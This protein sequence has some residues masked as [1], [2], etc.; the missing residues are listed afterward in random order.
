MG[1]NAVIGGS[2]IDE[3]VYT[4]PR[5]F[6]ALT[7]MTKN[8][9]GIVSHVLLRVWRGEGSPLLVLDTTFGGG[10]THTLVALYHLFKHPSIAEQDLEIRKILAEKDLRSVPNVAL[11]AID[12]HS[13]SSVQREG[14]VRTIWGEMA[15]QLGKYEMMEVYDQSLRRPDYKALQQLF[16]SVGNQSLFSLMN[17][18]IT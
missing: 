6:F 13:L 11:V 2:G 14:E 4:D 8:L 10:K 18:S 16:L 17:W 15:R 7:H 12:G 9:Q 5:K 3:N 1:F